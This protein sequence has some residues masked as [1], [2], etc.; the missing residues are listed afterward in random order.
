MIGM[1][2]QNPMA[3]LICWAVIPAA[4][5]GKRMCAD[6]PKQY[7]PVAGKTVIEPGL[8]GVITIQALVW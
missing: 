5:I 8:V 6:R 3:G 2:D 7:L 4:G 1:T